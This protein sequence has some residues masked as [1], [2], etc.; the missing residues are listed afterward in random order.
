MLSDTR[1]PISATSLRK[2]DLSAV[3]SAFPVPWWHYVRLLCVKSPEARRF[4]VAEALRSRWRVRQIECPIQN[5]LE[6]VSPSRVELWLW[7][8]LDR[9]ILTRRRRQR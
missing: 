3:D 5:V 1:A 7:E 6:K 2:S 4:Y 8:P 9:T